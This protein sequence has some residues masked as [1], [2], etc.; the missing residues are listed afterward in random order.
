MVGSCRRILCKRVGEKSAQHRVSDRSINT[1]WKYIKKKKLDFF[2]GSPTS[3]ETL[4]QD[5]ENE[6]RPSGIAQ[7]EVQAKEP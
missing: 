2:C 6:A 1:S 3:I 5:E 7:E 4:G